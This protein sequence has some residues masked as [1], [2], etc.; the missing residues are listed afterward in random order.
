MIDLDELAQAASE[1]DPLPVSAT[2]LLS[3]A[4]RDDVGI[5]DIV[6]VVEYDQALTGRLLRMANSS[7]SASSRPITNVRDAVV[8]L[9][10]SSVLSLALGSNVRGRM[11]T[12]VPAYGLD[13][14][15]LW[16]HSVA[17]A[18]AT[19]LM[20]RHCSMVLPSET[21]SAALLHDVGKLLM[22]RYLD[23]GVLEQLHAA[24]FASAR[25][26]MQAER[27]ILGVHYAELGALIVQTWGLPES[28]V[29][30][31]CYH[32][33]PEMWPEPICYAV[34]LADGIAQIVGAGEGSGQHQDVESFVH[35]IEALGMRSE[36]FE[37]IVQ[38]TRENL[39]A[40][41]DRYE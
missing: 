6:E 24:R 40:V 4:I 30:A 12:S 1:L 18:L 37:S 10:T 21:T 36:A 29:H 27:E 11:S 23:P 39:T 19:E 13:E 5:S 31:I 8:R 3:V 41:I 15:E 7:W 35:S 9:G 32:H 16:R 20:P 2:R 25:D 17:A 22:S 34:N 28:M 26:P 38:L 14:G 33:E